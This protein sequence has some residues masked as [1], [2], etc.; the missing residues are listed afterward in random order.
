MPDEKLCRQC[1]TN[2][3]DPDGFCSE[4]CA[5]RWDEEMYEMDEDEG[6]EA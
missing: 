5:K 6:G 3:A 1:Y 4:F 2:I